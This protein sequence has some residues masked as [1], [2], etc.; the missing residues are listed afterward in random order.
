[1]G[2]RT[3]VAVRFTFHSTT[4][5]RS[6]GL[7]SSFPRKERRETLGTRLSSTT[8]LRTAVAVHFSGC[9]LTV[10]IQRLRDCGPR[11]QFTV[12]FRIQRLR[13]CGP[14]WQFTLKFCIQRLRDCGPRWQF[15]LTF[16]ND[17]GT[18]DR[19]GSSL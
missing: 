7:S 17:C 16:C 11:W 4:Q 18:A 2:L 10:F 6:Q 5:P 1:M 3:A 9:P 12:T 15:T 8:R 13:D 14:R 19:G